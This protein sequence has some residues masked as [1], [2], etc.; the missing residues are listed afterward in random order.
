M[1]HDPPLSPRPFFFLR[2]KYP[3]IRSRAEDLLIMRPRSD[4]EV[5]TGFIFNEA[6]HLPAF[7]VLTYVDVSVDAAAHTTIIVWAREEAELMPGLFHAGE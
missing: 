1:W 4:D 6:P 2:G 5:T 3:A 7:P